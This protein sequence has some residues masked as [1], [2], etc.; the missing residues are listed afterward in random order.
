M[1]PGI[2]AERLSVVP[3][4]IDA[5]P[6]R[7]T[8]APLRAAGLLADGDRLAIWAGGMWSWLDPLT[9][10][11]A[12]E[13]LRPARPDLKLEVSPLWGSCA[14]PRAMLGSLRWCVLHR[15]DSLHHGR[16]SV[17]PP[18]QSR[19]MS[20]VFLSYRRA[21]TPGEAVHLA[22]DLM[23]EFGRSR[24]F[25][26][27]DGIKPGVRFEQRL[28]D[29]LEKSSYVL[30][31]IGKRWVGK[32]KGGR[33]IDDPNDYVRKEVAAALSRGDDVR[34][35]PVLIDQNVER[36]PSPGQ[37]PDPLVELAGRQAHPMRN[38]EWPHD[39][40][41]LLAEIDVPPRFVKRVRRWG[42]R[43]PIR[44]TLAGVAA[45]AAVG[46]ATALLVAGG[47]TANEDRAFVQR[48]DSL[49]ADSRPAYD[50]IGRTV[51]A[52][53][54][55]H[56]AMSRAR[57][58]R[59]LD[60]IIANRDRLRRR[61]RSLPARSAAAQRASEALTAAFSASLTNDREIEKCAGRPPG[62][63]RVQK[64]LDDT[65]AASD[66]ATDNKQHFT[67]VYN[68]LRGDLGLAPIAPKF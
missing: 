23:N 26:D 22:E 24:V 2:A 47:G 8:R 66:I 34:V 27:V 62:S 64:C 21:D 11:R 38:S 33:R 25:I 19:L 30:V 29:A 28:D 58:K 61:A 14:G 56:P 3:Y 6:P 32:T 48:V 53:L 68:H 5:V 35:I 49:L 41:R 10:L 65:K 55:G 15:S 57:I 1:T 60:R 42:R 59:S 17:L 16:R 13:R 50:E 31:L 43:H 45:A 46:L 7:P 37:L 51:G 44:A 18:S 40:S 54:S 36:M 39:L 9:A 67:K 52:M 63:S 4:G 20:G 12:L